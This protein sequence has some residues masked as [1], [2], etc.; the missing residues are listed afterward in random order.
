MLL[1]YLGLEADVFVDEK[2]WL[3]RIR[4]T[5][6]DFQDSDWE[7]LEDLHSDTDCSI[8]SS[9]EVSTS[10]EEESSNSCTS[11]DIE[12]NG[13]I[14]SQ[15]SDGS[16][17][18]TVSDSVTAVAWPTTLAVSKGISVKRGTSVMFSVLGQPWC[19]VFYSRS[20]IFIEIWN[21]KR[22]CR[23]NQDMIAKILRLLSSCDTITLMACLEL[24]TYVGH[25]RVQHH[26]IMPAKSFDITFSS[27]TLGS[28]FYNDVAI[29]M[30]KLHTLQPGAL[31]NMT[32]C[33]ADDER[34][35]STHRPSDIGKI[36][37]NL[38]SR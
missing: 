17:K 22:V 36:H 5:I 34:D 6:G 4:T 24:V 9:S 13:S 29:A 30:M 15:E 7:L 1:V 8:T 11:S 14:V 20:H 37:Q 3:D 27:L 10:W 12:V 31:L 32:L 38:L 25:H 35:D 23:V 19:E 2:K 28:G 21:G 26:S 33:V 18:P 16:Y